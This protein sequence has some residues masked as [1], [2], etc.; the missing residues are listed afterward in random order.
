MKK[1]VGIALLAGLFGGLA[2]MGWIALY[3]SAS[4]TSAVAVAREIT[5]TVFSTAADTPW[6]AWAGA[7]IHLA[8][9]LALGLAFV[10]LL[11][12]LSAAR[13]S[14]QT[15]WI[16]ALAALARS[17]PRFHAHPLALSD[18]EGTID[19]YM[20]ASPGTRRIM[21]SICSSAGSVSPLFL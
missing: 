9:S 1:I 14:V 13:P 20:T 11:W 2:E 18:Q 12:G 16:S 10:S 15:I 5:T 6:A 17:E 3:S 8:L 21:P 7:G 19:L 4:S